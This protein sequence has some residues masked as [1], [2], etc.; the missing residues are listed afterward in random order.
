[1]KP[2][3]NEIKGTYSLRQVLLFT[4]QAFG[5]R[6]FYEKRDVLKR[7]YVRK[8][9]ELFPDREGAPDI[10]YE[11]TTRSYPQYKPYI[12]KMRGKVQR[13]V[14]HDYDITLEMDELSMDT[15]FWKARV[16]TGKLI[17]KA[18]KSLVKTIDRVTRSRWMKERDIKLKNAKDAKEKKTIEEAYKKKISDHIK[19]APY[20]NDGDYNAQVNGINL[21]FAYRDAYAFKSHGHLYGK[22]QYKLDR[23]SK[24][25][26]KNIMFLPKHLIRVLEVLLQ[27]G[28]IEN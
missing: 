10:R 28:I 6:F 15:P 5:T 12:N 18:P 1:M 22:W 23:P 19:K 20:L 26:P 25:N 21:D 11:I 27:K 13:S 4:H 24:I 3:G 14:H 16:G 2:S 9:I 7:I 17:R 8:V